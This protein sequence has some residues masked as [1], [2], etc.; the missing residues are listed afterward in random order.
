MGCEQLSEF[1]GAVDMNIFQKSIAQ[2]QRVFTLS[3]PPPKGWQL[4]RKSDGSG[5]KKPASK[6]PVFV[7]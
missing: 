2:F 4:R 6:K 3:L 5:T 7:L 1:W